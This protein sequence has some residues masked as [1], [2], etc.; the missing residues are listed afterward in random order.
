MI[1]VA[2]TT[3]DAVEI[4]W[5]RYFADKPD[6]IAMLES[7]LASAK[8]AEAVYDLRKHLRMSQQSFAVRV[9][10][11]TA[12]IGRLEDGCYRGD[13]MTML[14][15]IA[16]AC[17]QNLVMDFQFVPKNKTRKRTRKTAKAILT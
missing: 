16:D 6:M 4:L 5:H 2:K 17:D 10:T 13:A 15:R 14:R 1:Q 12:V 7:E 11:T 3:T 9:G 8:V